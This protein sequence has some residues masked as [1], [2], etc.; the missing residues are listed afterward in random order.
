MYALLEITKGRPNDQILS[1][2]RRTDEQKC[3]SSDKLC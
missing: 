1:G 2:A 3:D